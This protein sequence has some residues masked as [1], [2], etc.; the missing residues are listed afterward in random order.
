VIHTTVGVYPN[1]SFRVN[2]V[3]DAHL[4]EHVE[5]NLR[6]RPGRILVVDGFIVHRG[7]NALTDEEILNIVATVT[8]PTKDTQPYW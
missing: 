1:K 7:Y 6:L 5:Y 8:R 2:G 3:P 4:N